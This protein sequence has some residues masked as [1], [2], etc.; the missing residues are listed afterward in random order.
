MFAA[1]VPFVNANY[2]RSHILGEVYD[3][4]TVEA[5]DKLD[6]LE[7]HPDWYTRTPVIV[8]LDDG[9]GSIE[10]EIY[11]NNSVDDKDAGGGFG[12]VFIGSV[13]FRDAKMYHNP[14]S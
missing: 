9:K 7:G 8:D 6:R 13:D 14:G 2:A 1:G 10:A 12:A 3:V 5:L 11:F 4:L